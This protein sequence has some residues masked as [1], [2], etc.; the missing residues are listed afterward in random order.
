LENVPEAW[1][2]RPQSELPLFALPGVWLFPYVI[3]PL[4]VFEERYRQMIEDNLDGPGRIVLGTVQAGHED[5]LEGSPPVYDIAGLG[6]IGRH[7]SLPDGR[8]NILLVGLRRVHVREVESDRL[9][10]KVVTEP[11][12]RKRL[13]DAILERT[14]GTTTIPPQ[15]SISHLTDLLTLR[16]PLPQEVVSELF[17]DLDERHRAERALAEH[18]IRPHPDASEE[19]E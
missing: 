7:E 8:Y 5:E 12:L 4:H 13:V 15:V 11:A 10:R 6:E 18:E 2:P 16:M 17:C 1:P 19:G 3:L 14:V 9:Y